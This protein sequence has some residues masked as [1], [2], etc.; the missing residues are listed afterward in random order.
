MK[1]KSG[2][3]KRILL[4]DDDPA[5]L[6]IFSLLLREAG[7]RSGHGRACARCDGLGSEEAS[8]PGVGRYS[9]ANRGWEGIGGG[10]EKFTDTKEIPLW[11][12]LAMTGRERRKRLTRRG[13][14]RIPD[15]AGGRSE[16]SAAS[17]RVSRKR[18]YQASG[19][20]IS[21]SPTRPGWQRKLHVKGV[22]CASIVTTAGS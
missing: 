1:K 2:K 18:K 5:I 7:Y 10:V 11:R 12:S 8:G 14:R 17:R 9:H 16:I 15:K 4:V 19:L 6:E 22:A 21:I 13:L 20:A 3:K